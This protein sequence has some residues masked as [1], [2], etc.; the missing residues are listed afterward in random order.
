MHLAIHFLFSACI[1]YSYGH[2]MHGAPSLV[3]R[4]DGMA[5]LDALRQAI[6][7]FQTKFNITEQEPANKND[8]Q[9]AGSGVPASKTRRQ[10]LQRRVDDNLAPVSLMEVAGGPSKGKFLGKMSVMGRGR[11]GGMSFRTLFDTAFSDIF[12]PS[13]NC[14]PEMGCK[15]PSSEKYDEKGNLLVC[16]S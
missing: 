5:D 12:I 16:M 14:A 1:S 15:G 2:V 3:P 7:S 8:T 9:P 11:T 6:I 4:A 13:K 10:S